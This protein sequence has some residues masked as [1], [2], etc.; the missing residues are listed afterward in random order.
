MESTSV[1]A[2]QEVNGRDFFDQIYQTDLRVEAEW[3]R[4]TAAHKTRSISTLLRSSR[5]RPHSLLEI[6]SGTG[7]VIRECKRQRLAETFT[8]IDYSTTALSYLN[9][10]DPNIATRQ[11][12]ITSGNFRLDIPVD[13]VIC[14]HVIEH[15][16]EPDAFLAALR[17]RIDFKFA[18]IEVPLEDLFG[19]KWRWRGRDRKQNASGHVQFFTS[20]KFETLLVRNGFRIL[21][22]RRYVPTLTLET[23]RFITDRQRL[24]FGRQLRK[25]LTNNML[26]KL[27]APLWSRLYYAHYA[28]LCTK[29][30]G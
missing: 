16:E 14:S 20:K 2:K 12:D 5:F 7:A 23:I 6:G 15:L 8:A 19:H 22:R 18:V 24:T 28:V 11:A 10:A 13:A 29:A 9:A 1:A 25:V 26:P 4:L 21:A 27:T 17:D 30:E 3:A